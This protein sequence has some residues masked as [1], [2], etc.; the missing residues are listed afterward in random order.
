M[1]TKPSFDHVR[2]GNVL[3]ATP[4]RR[5]ATSRDP[6]TQLFVATDADSNLTIEWT[7]SNGG[8]GRFYYDGGYA[9]QKR[10]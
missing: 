1:S 10:R 8:Q 4:L 5:V 6:V 3:M 7:D 2:V 9:L